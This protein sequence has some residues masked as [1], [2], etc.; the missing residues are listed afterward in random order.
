MCCALLSR[1]LRWPVIRQISPPGTGTPRPAVAEATIRA[2]AV[3]AGIRLELLTVAWMA[4]EAALAMGAGIAARSVL[5]T[6]FGADSLIELL[7]GVTLLWRLRTEASDGNPER[8]DAVEQRAIGVSA[9]LLIVLCVY[10]F[11]SAGAGLF[12]RIEPQE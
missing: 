2:K 6:A 8:L 3:R 7:S 9:L 5:L 1:S 12:L 10:V 4:V 11:V